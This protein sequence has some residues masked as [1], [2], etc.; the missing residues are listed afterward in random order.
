MHLESGATHRTLV[1]VDGNLDG[2]A[3][4]GPQQELAGFAGNAHDVI[5]TLGYPALVRRHNRLVVCLLYTSP[6]PRDS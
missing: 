5:A 2:V 1:A 3:S 6:S 4:E